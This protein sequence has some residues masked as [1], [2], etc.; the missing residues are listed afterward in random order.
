MNHTRSRAQKA[1]E[2]SLTNHQIDELFS[3]STYDEFKIE[4]VL[5]KGAY[6][7]TYRGTHLPSEIPVAIKIY[8][9][10]S[11]GKLRNSIL[12]EIDVLGRLDHV[13]IVKLYTAFEENQ[14]FILIM[15]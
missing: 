2:V 4:N 14:K 8:N 6:A 11:T 15:E 7:T 9:S 12:M 5:G 10:K 1:P 3:D 13:N